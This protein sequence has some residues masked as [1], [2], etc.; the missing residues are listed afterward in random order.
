MINV[1]NN[2]ISMTRGDT[3]ILSLDL[4]KDGEMFTPSA[5]D[6]IRFAMSKRYKSEKKYELILVKQIPN[7]SL[8]LQLDPEDTD[9]LDYG[10]YNYDIEIT[11][12]NG[13]VDTFIL[14]QISI[15]KEVE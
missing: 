2:T 15:T 9:E 4:T 12:A 10:T 13:D 3:L 14:D 11:Y 5:N 7:D 1:N 6:Y 8:V